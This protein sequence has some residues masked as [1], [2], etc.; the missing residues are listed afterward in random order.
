MLICVILK[1][2]Q[3]RRLLKDPEKSKALENKYQDERV[4]FIAQ[5]SYS[6]AFWL[7][8]Y[9]EFVGILV[10]MYMKL[11]NY[12]NL[13]SIIVCVQLLLYVGASFFYSKKY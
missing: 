13:L 6:F 2:I 10:T 3:Q 4:I 5:K 8:V 11:D 9:S 1:A 12:T 7:S